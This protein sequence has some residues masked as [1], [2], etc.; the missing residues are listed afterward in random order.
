[1][2]KGSGEAPGELSVVRCASSMTI[3]VPHQQ[4][5]S[6][7]PPGAS[8]AQPR[9]TSR[10]RSPAPGPE[11][12][13]AENAEVRQ[14]RNSECGGAPSR[15]GFVPGVFCGVGRVPEGLS[16]LLWATD[17]IRIRQLTGVRS[18]L[19]VVSSARW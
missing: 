19:W 7:R 15:R 1:M 17:G 2:Y 5:A 6:V 12:F 13:R 14:V 18:G 10:T 11:R 9:R 8:P 3:Q 4:A 16:A